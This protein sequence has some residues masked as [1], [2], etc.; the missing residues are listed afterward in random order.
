MAISMLQTQG[1]L[2]LGVRELAQAASI[3][4]PSVY[5]HFSSKE[6]LTRQAMSAYRED[7]YAELTGL[8]GTA[9]GQ[10]GAYLELF[11]DMLRDE[12]KVCLGLALAA[13][14][15]VLPPEVVDE[16]RKF[17]D[18]NAEWIGSVWE[19]GLSD[20]TINSK[21]TGPDAGKILFGAL[22][23]LMLFALL[24]TSPVSAFLSRS[25]GLLRAMGVD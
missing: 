9:A 13:D 1:Y 8:H 7:Q 20:G 10:L 14:R 5:N 23:G 6:E 15:N 18:Q 21:L 22:E 4:A 19:A 16:V 24:D 17:A 3:R 12:R 25:K 11:A 2:A